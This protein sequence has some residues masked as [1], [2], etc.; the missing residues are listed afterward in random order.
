MQHDTSHCDTIEQNRFTFAV[1]FI[2]G[3]N[4]VLNAITHQRC[5]DAHVA[6]AKECTSRTGRWKTSSDS[7]SEADIL[8]KTMQL[9]FKWQLHITFS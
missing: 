8:T 9:F 5:V 1:A 6:V 4:T 3:K 7:L 2:P